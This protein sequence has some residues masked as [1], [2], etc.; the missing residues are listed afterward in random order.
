MRVRMAIQKHIWESQGF[1]LNIDSVRQGAEQERYDTT[2][3]SFCTAF[4]NLKI[5]VPPTVR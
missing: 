3:R 5:E 1:E 2:A 4:S